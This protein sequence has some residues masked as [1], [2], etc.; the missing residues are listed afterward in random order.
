MRFF[1]FWSCLLAVYLM[2]SLLLVRSSFASYLERTDLH[3]VSRIAHRLEDLYGQ[4][5]NWQFIKDNRQAVEE[6]IKNSMGPGGHGQRGP[7]MEPPPDMEPPP[8]M[9]PPGD[10]G[11]RRGHP[12]L[13]PEIL[14]LIA[15]VNVFDRQGHK[16][17]GV[18]E[19]SPDKPGIVL[20]SGGEKIGSLVLTP[21]KAPDG[22]STDTFFQDVR[23]NLTLLTIIVLILS[24]VLTGSTQRR[25]RLRLSGLLAGLTALTDGQNEKRLKTGF[26]DEVG[27]LES[28]YNKLADVLVAQDRGHRQWVADTSHELRTPI[29]VLRA[30]VEAFQDGV[31][32]VTP[33]NLSVLHNEIMAL[34]KLVDDLHWL[35]KYDVGQIKNV[36]VMTDI[37]GTLQDVIEGLEERFEAK[38]LKVN[39][40]V[41]GAD[42][43]IKY[44]ANLDT[45]RLRQVFSNLLENSL[46]YTD[47]GG[48][49]HVSAEIDS[50]GERLIMRFDDSAPGVSDEV[51]DKMFERFFRAETSRSRTLGGSGLGLAI[52]KNNMQMLGGTIEGYHSPLGGVRM[53]LNL[54]LQSQGQIDRKSETNG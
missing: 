1:V 16:V 22:D 37:G 42:G 23:G 38:G 34:S 7:S 41:G 8:E 48:V 4:A 36:P 44:L 20:T 35:A 9:G 13:P 51:L 54:P 24:G 52:C 5:G 15:R 30:Q 53:E 28:Q 43:E 33:R 40:T 49:V 32:E 21:E 25:M 12:P 17:W 27:E 14:D 26:Q 29:A 19:V 2:S 46:R 50:S 39:S 47:K 18:A 45:G 6:E 31:Q 11:L 10:M 3:R